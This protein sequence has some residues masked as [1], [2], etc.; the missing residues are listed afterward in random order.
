MIPLLNEYVGVQF[1]FHGRY[2]IC[3]IQ[4]V[5]ITNTP[6]TKENTPRLFFPILESIS[7]IGVDMDQFFPKFRN[8]TI[9]IN[10]G[11]DSLAFEKRLTDLASRFMIEGGCVKIYHS[12]TPIKEETFTDNRCLVFEGE[13]QAINYTS[14]GTEATQTASITINK[15][16]DDWL[17]NKQITSF[18]SQLAPNRSLGKWLPLVI[19]RDIQVVPYSISPDNTAGATGFNFLYG[20]SFRSTTFGNGKDFFYKGIQKY[21]APDLETIEGDRDKVYREIKSVPNF[22]LPVYEQVGGLPLQFSV[23]LDQAQAFPIPYTPGVSDPHIITSLVVV[24]GS[25]GNPGTEIPDGEI[26]IRIHA[27]R[28]NLQRPTSPDDFLAE[29]V[30]D[31]STL[32]VEYAN[33]VPFNA[34]ATFNKPVPICSTEKGYWISIQGSNEDEPNSTTVL[35]L[36]AFNA[37]T[38]AGARSFITT[39]DADNSVNQNTWASHPNQDL[40]MSFQLL[41]IEFEDFPKGIGIPD[42][43]GIEVPFV[44]V[45]YQ[46]YVQTVPMEQFARLDLIL[47]VDG[48]QDED[49]AI[50]GTPVTLIEQPQ[51]IAELLMHRYDGQSW[52]PGLFDKTLFQATHSQ[53]NDPNSGFYRVIAGRTYGRATNVAVLREIMRNSYSQFFYNGLNSSPK[54]GVLAVGQTRNPTRTITDDDAKFQRWFSNRLSTVVNFADFNFDRRLDGLH[55]QN[56]A[57]QALVRDYSQTTRYSPYDGGIGS[58]LSSISNFHFRERRASNENF[59][60]VSDLQSMN[61]VAQ[62]YLRLGDLPY[63]LAQVQV[64]YA[65]FKDLQMFE[66]VNL[67]STELPSLRGTNPR[68]YKH[69]DFCGI[70][71]ENVKARVYRGELFS[72]VYSK[73]RRSPAVLNL[74]FRLLIQENDPLFNYVPESL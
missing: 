20:T 48:I 54:Y 5:F 57:D 43:N 33:Q 30:I 1:S 27:Q 53:Y 26:S 46:D 24:I 17:I 31:K 42:E 22:D 51:H 11:R 16:L 39:D 21:L 45:K 37:G 29:A 70:A 13:I 14:N 19:G 65:E 18:N 74:L 69:P 47:E 71:G 59:D 66:V 23:N 72:M 6:V 68:V 52:N 36:V 55:F 58:Q 64:P 44:L 60:W 3:D 9:R 2:D 28:P 67:I 38:P 49:G 73:G 61:S 40:S 62:L 8:G 15:R 34:V 10:A 35:G 41:G 63:M 12:T 56:E 7:N 4:E 50:T 25:P 32:A